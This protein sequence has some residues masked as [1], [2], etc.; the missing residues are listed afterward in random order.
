MES[1]AQWENTAACA[2]CASDRRRATPAWMS[3]LEATAAGALKAG[4]VDRR[5]GEPRT[6]TPTQI[7]RGSGSSDGKVVTLAVERT[8]KMTSVATRASQAK[9]GGA[10]QRCTAEWV[11]RQRAA[12]HFGKDESGKDWHG[13]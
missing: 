4:S 6:A 13:A 3:T 1:V 2:S 5:G 8:Y 10:A 12:K 7:A 11:K 9:R